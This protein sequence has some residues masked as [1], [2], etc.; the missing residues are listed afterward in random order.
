MLKELKRKWRE[1]QMQ[2]NL[3]T[4]IAPYVNL[5]KNGQSIATGE[6][7]VLTRIYTGQLMYVDRRDVS[8]AP[9][10]MM[11]GLWEH[12]ITELF[13]RYIKPDSVVFDIGANFGYFGLV[14]GAYN[15]EGRLY[16][17]DANPVFEPLI[18]KSLL[19]NG[20]ERRSKVVTCAVSAESGAKVRLM[21]DPDLWGGSTLCPPGHEGAENE[22]GTVISETLSLDDYCKQHDISRV[23]VVKLDI[24]GHEQQALKGMLRVISENP[25]MVIFMEYTKGAYSEQFV[26]QLQHRFAVSAIVDGVK[27]GVRDREHLEGFCQGWVML[28]LEPRD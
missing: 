22:P 18:K 19:V 14:A 25:R 15:T 2:L 27:R 3:L 21:C 23:D 16:F 20:L 4:D 17:F 26:S 11:S 28:V 8:I 12:E 1:L 13:R 24:E 6:N 5:I 7:E 9:H 10:L